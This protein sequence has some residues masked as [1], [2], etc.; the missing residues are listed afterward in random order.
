MKS[1]GLG[2]TVKTITDKLGI[3]QCGGCKKRQKQ[4]NK[5]VPYNFDLTAIVKGLKGKK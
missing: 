3:K 1:R 5:V 2:D 4:W